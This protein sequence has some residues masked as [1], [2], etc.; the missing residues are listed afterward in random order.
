MRKEKSKRAIL[1]VL[2]CLMVVGGVVAALD[3]KNVE[4]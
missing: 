4:P 3:E 2:L 1:P